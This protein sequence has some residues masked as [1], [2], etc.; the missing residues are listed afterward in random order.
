MQVA[1]GGEG[2]MRGAVRLRVLD[3]GTVIGDVEVRE[4]EGGAAAAI[5]QNLHGRWLGASCGDVPPFD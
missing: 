1:C 5:T 4:G 3:R 2:R